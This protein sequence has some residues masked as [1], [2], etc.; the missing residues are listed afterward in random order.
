MIFKE[1]QKRAMDTMNH[2][3]KEYLEKMNG[4]LPDGGEENQEIPVRQ[5]DD[6]P[7][8]KDNLEK[9]D[10]PA[11]VISALLTFLPIILVIALIMIVSIK[12]LS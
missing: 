5:V 3:N 7:F 12:L 11:M 1:R 6:N 4:P 10:L 8:S 2:R 9:G